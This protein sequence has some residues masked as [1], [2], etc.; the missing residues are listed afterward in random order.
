MGGV[1]VRVAVGRRGAS[2]A[3]VRY[4]TRGPATGRDEGAI[5][6]RHYPEYVL[7]GRD[8][9]ELR[10]N[11]EAYAHQRE[12]DE[13]GRRRGDDGEQRTHYRVILSCE[14]RLDTARARELADEYL[15]R[16]FPDARA[17]AAVHQDTDH[18]HVHIHLQARDI[19]D[20]KLHFDDE[21]YRDL[22]RAWAEIYGR[23]V[24]RD[25]IREHQGRKE[26]TRTWRRDYAEARLAGR[27]PP[28]A[29]D[30]DDRRPGLVAARSRERRNHGD[31]EARDRGPQRA[32]TS[33]DRDAAGGGGAAPDG[34]RLLE[35]AA[36]AADRL[37]R[38]LGDVLSAAEAVLRARDRDRGGYGRGPGVDDGEN[39]D[40]RRRRGRGRGRGR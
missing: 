35:R 9:G 13:L 40:E 20:R 5:L 4:I 22:D 3:N 38:D 36:G 17:L 15:G 6:A 25:L 26:E 11:L 14:K 28:P 1:F 7:D 32:I 34:E 23:E 39:E 21:R 31:D 2:A 16:T 30:R 24:G 33:D 10:G 18:T 12:E 29:P 37:E 8:Y 27:E 19:Q